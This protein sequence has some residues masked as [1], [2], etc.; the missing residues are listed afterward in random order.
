[1]AE[2]G[3]L[4]PSLVAQRFGNRRPGGDAPG[5]ARQ[6][7]RRDA[8]AAVRR[9]PVLLRVGLLGGVRPGRLVVARTDG[10]R[11]GVDPPLRG[12]ARGARRAPWSLRRCA[13]LVRASQPRRAPDRLEP[14]LRPAQL[15]RAG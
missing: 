8:S 13:A 11:T 4:S 1:M 5:G 2:Y 7:E 9:V 12:L 6:G 15:A 14:P 3:G 10:P